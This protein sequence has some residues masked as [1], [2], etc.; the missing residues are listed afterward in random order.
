MGR[1]LVREDAAA[2]QGV[3][4]GVLSRTLAGGPV[5][6]TQVRNEVLSIAHSTLLRAARD[7]NQAA[8][9]NRLP[10]EILHLIVSNLSLPDR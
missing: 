4:H 7:H 1:G 3:L 9:T 5:D 2:V 10:V 8:P 6:F